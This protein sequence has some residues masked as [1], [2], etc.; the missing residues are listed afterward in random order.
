ME[1]TKFTYSANFSDEHDLSCTAPEEGGVG[2]WQWRTKTND[3]SSVVF[4]NHTICRYGLE[5]YNTPPACPWNACVDLEC[6]ICT[7]DWYE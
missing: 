6:T 4:T 3:G 1:D 7:D 5:H 2:I